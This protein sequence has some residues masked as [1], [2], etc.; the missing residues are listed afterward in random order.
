MI[1]EEKGLYS[2]GTVADLIGEHPETLR[3]WEKNDLL[4]PD[5]ASYQRKYSNNDLLRLKFIKYLMD[6][7]GLNV[8]GVKQLT[9]MYS[10]WYKRNCKG[11]AKKN[12]TSAIN[13]S[14]PC[15]RVEG[16]FCLV[17]SDKSELCNSCEMFKNCKG[18]NGC[19]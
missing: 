11:G 16:T 14:K 10:C 4:R 5:R 8:A 19:K 7:K 3:V 12:S 18:C 1:D 2:I 17:A 13:E 15:W 6:Q 9:S